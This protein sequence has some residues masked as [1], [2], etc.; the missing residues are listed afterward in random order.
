M[1]KIITNL[2]EIMTVEQEWKWTPLLILHMLNNVPTY[3]L[4][5]QLVNRLVLE[6]VSLKYQNY[7]IFL[8]SLQHMFAN[9]AKKGTL[10]DTDSLGNQW[11][12]T[13]EKILPL[14]KKL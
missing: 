12:Q 3:F 11:K 8:W 13:W 14:Q 7:F 9:S 6:Y 10:K 2:Y 4:H 1:Q 5:S